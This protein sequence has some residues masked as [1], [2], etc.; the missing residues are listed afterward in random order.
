MHYLKCIE[1][2]G[3]NKDN[4]E[5]IEYSCFVTRL[6]PTNLFLR[7]DTIAKIQKLEIKS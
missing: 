7:N 2:V 5:Y 6:N 1:S 3:K 4:V